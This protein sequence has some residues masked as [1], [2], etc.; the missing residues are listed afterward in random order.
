MSEIVLPEDIQDEVVALMLEDDHFASN[1]YRRI[2][3][4]DIFSGDQRRSLVREILDY[5]EDFGE[6]PKDTILPYIEEKQVQNILSGEAVDGIIDYLFK[7]VSR[8]NGIS[9]AFIERHFNTFLKKRIAAAGINRLLKAQDRF[10]HSPERLIDIMR[11]TITAADS[12]GDG[13]VVEC[14]SEDPVF[15]FRTDLVTR[16]GVDL[17]DRTLG[18]GIHAGEFGI[19]QAYTGVGKTWAC[20]H[21]SKHA[22]RLGNS[23]LAGFMET[24]N[25]LIRLRMKMTFSGMT[26]EEIAADPQT[27]ASRIQEGSTHHAEVFLLSEDE[28]GMSVDELPSVLEETEERNHGE[29][30]RLVLLDSADDMLPPRGKYHSELEKTTAKYTWLK[31]FAKD[32]ERAI[33]TTV[34]SQRIGETRYWLTKGTVAEDI[35]KS[36]KATLGVSLNA[37]R[38]E[39]EKGFMRWLVFKHSEGRTG[40]RCW[41]RSDFSRG[42]LYT[43]SGEYRKEQYKAMVESARPL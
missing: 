42:Q 38:D 43:E 31:N 17:F 14:L 25:R 8:Q 15:D 36:R 12:T 30:I 24:S 13:V 16:F 29:K 34:Q 39:V 35:N 19:L 3:T 5:V 7:I 11:E 1:C 40:G 6:A 32:T 10:V 22:V 37:T 20:C 18:G 33:I 23:C 27:V 2:A 26:K 9:P 21:L 28:K 41:I 4:P